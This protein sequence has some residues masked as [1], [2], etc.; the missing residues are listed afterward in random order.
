MAQAVNEKPSA[1]RIS[2]SASSGGNTNIFVTP[3][4]TT[5][6][7][8]RGIRRLALVLLGQRGQGDTMPSD[9]DLRQL[10]EFTAAETKVALMLCRGRAP[11]EIARELR[12]SVATVRSHVSALLAKTGT[13]RQVQ[14]VSLLT[15]LPR[16]QPATTS[17]A[18]NS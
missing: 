12:L 15:S 4:P 3:L 11:K 13:S 5:L 9:D 18:A 8:S 2:V 1:T 10:F 14:L 7:Y 17:Q 16:G 6:G